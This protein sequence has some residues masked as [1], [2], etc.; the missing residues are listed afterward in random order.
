MQ[1]LVR[2]PWVTDVVQTLH[3][4]LRE[5]HARQTQGGRGGR[6][7][8]HPDRLGD[9]TRGRDDPHAPQDQEAEAQKRRARHEREG[10]R[11]HEDPPAEQGQG[12]IV[13]VVPR[14]ERRLLQIFQDVVDHADGALERP[15]AHAADGVFGRVI[16]PGGIGPA[17]QER[18]HF[19]FEERLVVRGVGQTQEARRDAPQRSRRHPFDAG[20]PGGA[21]QQLLRP[22]GGWSGHRSDQELAP[23]D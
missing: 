6:N 16:A 14:I 10:G 19:P 13:R 2:H 11:R 18:R 4:G 3:Q 21:Q 22:E 5:K 7:D 1:P 12:Q 8:D 20:I 17:E 15:L 9:G 23:A